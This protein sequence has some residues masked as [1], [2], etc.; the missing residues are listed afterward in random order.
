MLYLFRGFCPEGQGRRGERQAQ[1]RL[2]REVR[3]VAFRRHGGG[4]DPF[5]RFGQVHGFD[6]AV[7]RQCRGGQHL[8]RR[9]DDHAAGYARPAGQRD[10]RLLLGADDRSRETA[11]PEQYHPLERRVD[12]LG[13]GVQQED[14]DLPLRIF[15]AL[16]LSGG[17]AA[18]VDRSVSGYRRRQ[19][20]RVRASARRTRN[21]H[22]PRPHPAERE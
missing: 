20:G 16:S 7:H 4:G 22:R 6:P 15:G 14:Q 2:D 13:A 12:L 18:A 1:T 5:R 17:R 3:S 19:A 9:E 21:D 8:V 11:L 10:E